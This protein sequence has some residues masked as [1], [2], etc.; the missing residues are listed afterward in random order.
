MKNIVFVI[1]LLLFPIS[2]QL[3]DYISVKTKIL[4]G[5]PVELSKDVVGL[6]AVVIVLI[7]ATVAC[8]LYERG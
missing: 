2:M 4:R 7:W 6:T 8:L 1:W 5:M 3:E